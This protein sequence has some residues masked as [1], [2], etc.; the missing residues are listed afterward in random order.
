MAKPVV[1]LGHSFGGRVAVELAAAHLGEMG[2]L[3]LTGA[4]LFPANPSSPRKRPLL[5]YRAVRRLA[6]SGLVSEAH[7]DAMRDKYGSADYRAASGVM[8]DVLVKS[9]AEERSEA[10]SEALSAISCPVELVWG[11]LDTAAPLTVA[12]R[13]ASTLGGPVNMTVVPGSSHMTPL[14]APDELRAAIER[15]RAGLDVGRRQ[16]TPRSAD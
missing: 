3:V 9:I 16:S 4:P 2:G 1:V 6:R 8:R 13:I 12:E 7:L 15:L 5:R 11:E 14:E 10:Y